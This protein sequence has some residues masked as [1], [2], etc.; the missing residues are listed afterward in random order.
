MNL[1]TLTSAPSL[2]QLTRALF[3]IGNTT[4]GGG[5]ITMIIIGREFVERRG[6]LTQSQFDVAFSL[7]RV[8]PG[9]NIVAFCAAIGSMLRGWRGAVLAVFALTFPSALI[10]VLLMQGFE[11]WRS[12]PWAMAALGATTAA[13]TGMMWSTVWLLTKPHVGGWEKTIRAAVILGGAF[14]AAW[15]GV[16]PVPI[17]VVA[18]LAGFL[19]PERSGA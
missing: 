1:Q 5:F 15:M 13:V 3:R 17:I 4:F 9:T 14:A 8:T 2:G 19:W 18:T 11:S 16:T 12:H 7:A 6:W 10:A